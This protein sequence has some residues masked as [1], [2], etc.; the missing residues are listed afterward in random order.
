MAVLLFECDDAEQAQ[1]RLAKLPLYS[2]GLVDFEL[3]PLVP[4]AGYSRLSVEQRIR[5]RRPQIF[6]GILRTCGKNPSGR[7]YALVCAGS[8]CPLQAQDQVKM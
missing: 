6:T 8:D 2:A 3:I 1:E 4:Y 7:A 5:T